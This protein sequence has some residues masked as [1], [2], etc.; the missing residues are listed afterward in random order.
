[1]TSGDGL[2]RSLRLAR[3][4]RYEQ[5]E[6]ERFYRALAEDS[7]TQV[8]HHADLAGAWVLDVGGGP[9]WF[10]AAFTLAGARYCVVERDRR[11]AADRRP[12]ANP[13]TVV[14]DG[15]ALPVRHG[16]F[17]VCF[18]SNVLEHVPRPWRFL[19]ELVSAVRGGGIVFCAFTNWL[20]P[21]GGH[22]TSPWHL[23]GGERAARRYEQ[24]YGRPPK[25]RIGRSLFPVHVGEVLR[26]AQANPT[27]DLVDAWPRYYPKWCRRVVSVPGLRELA[28]W[29]LAIVLRRR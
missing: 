9:G 28:T 8:S 2:G 15:S 27:V 29:N 22:E 16:A 19:D 6:P 25:N 4:F 11:E 23:L 3:A 21:W 13:P 17:D 14:A 26:W 24:R 10:H 20:S 7:V 1:M 5:S 12:G 18:S